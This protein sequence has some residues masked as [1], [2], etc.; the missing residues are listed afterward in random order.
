MSEHRIQTIWQRTSADFTYA[1]YNRDHEWRFKSA[2]TVGASAS[3]QYK[4]NPDLPDPEDAFVAALSSCHMLTF[5]AVA[6]KHGFVVDR[7]EDAAVG[8]LEKNAQ[9]K[10]AITRAELSPRIVFAGE[11]QPDAEML[12][13]MHDEAHHGCFIANSVSTQVSVKEQASG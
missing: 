7:Y 3:P 11:R 13:R 9:S 10:L 5:L 6:A 4:G 2:V 1:S 8:Y 12:R